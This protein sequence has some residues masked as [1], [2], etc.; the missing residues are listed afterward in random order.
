MQYF[1][2][3]LKPVPKERPRMLK[4]GRVYTPKRTKQAEDA[5]RHYLRNNGVQKCSGAVAVK[6]VFEF[7][8][9]KSNKSQH[10]TKRPDLDNLVKLVL[11]GIQDEYGAIADDKDIIHMQ[12]SKQYGTIDQ[13]KLWIK[14]V[15]ETN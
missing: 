1:E 5:I 11:D 8:R 12:A 10:H 7:K 9:P 6:I 14:E 4:N 15:E 3:P 13:I 2:I